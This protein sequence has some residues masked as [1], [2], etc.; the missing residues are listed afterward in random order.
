MYMHYLLIKISLPTPA[1]LPITHSS[2]PLLVSI[3]HLGTFSSTY[4][5]KKVFYTYVCD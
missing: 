3:L 2:Q 1:F 4:I 5:S